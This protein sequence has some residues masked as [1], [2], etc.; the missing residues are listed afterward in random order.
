MPVTQF[1]WWILDDAMR[2]NLFGHK[3]NVFGIERKMETE[4]LGN[5]IENRWDGK[6]VQKQ[7]VSKPVLHF[8]H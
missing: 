5:K 6:Q 2:G 3:K 4:V 1:S 7:N 8:I